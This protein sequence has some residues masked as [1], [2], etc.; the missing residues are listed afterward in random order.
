MNI[1][2][3]VIND[4]HIIQ[5]IAEKS[6]LAT[7]SDILSVEQ[8]NYML[9]KMYSIEEIYSHFKDINWKYFLLTNENNFVGFFGYQLN[10]K[11]NTTK[12]HRIYVLPEFLGKG[13][14]RFAIDFLKNDVYLSGN[15]RII[16]NVNKNNSAKNFYESQGF[17]IYDSGVFDIGNGFVMDDYL[18]EFHFD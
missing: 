11:L 16:L 9:K 12:L 7:Y 13:Y 3:A 1:K 10:F 8:I 15:K 18:M 14:G 6:W 5:N 2:Q 4:V 17:K